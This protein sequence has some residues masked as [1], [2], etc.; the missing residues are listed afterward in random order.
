MVQRYVLFNAQSNVNFND[1]ISNLTLCLAPLLMHVVAGVPSPVY[2]C[3]NRPRW[4]DYIGH[5]NPTSI[6]WRYF[7]ITD[8]RVRTKSGQWTSEAMAASNTLFWTPLGWDGSERMINES[9]RFRIRQLRATRM[10]I[11][12]FSALKTVIVTCQGIQALYGLLSTLSRKN[13]LTISVI[14]IFMPI[15]TFGLLRLPAAMWL[16]DIENYWSEN[17]PEDDEMVPGSIHSMDELQ[18]IV[19]PIHASKRCVV[20][21]HPNGSWRGLAVQAFFALV[22]L[23]LLGVGI[24]STVPRKPLGVANEISWM[25]LTDLVMGISYILFLS[26]TICTISSYFVRGHANTTVIPCVNH[27]WYKIYTTVLVASMALVFVIA[28]LETR[29]SPCGMMTTNPPQLDGMEGMCGNSTLVIPMNSPKR[30][31]TWLPWEPPLNSINETTW[32][33]F[34]PPFGL[35]WRMPNR[36]YEVVVF[37]GWCHLGPWQSTGYFDLMAGNFSAS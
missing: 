5:I 17:D 24:A 32:T 1:W 3:A 7:A 14:T 35:I 34:M 18:L 11:L 10:D 13:P 26:V 21:Y 8:R 2:L 15:A 22:T 4:H 6:V 36:T 28:S 27:L 12:S 30:S 16:T 33:D 29:K 19:Y 23:F 25:T 37:D 20:E 31:R 9:A